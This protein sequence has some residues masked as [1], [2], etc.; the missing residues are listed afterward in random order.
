[1]ATP[2]SIEEDD[3]PGLASVAAPVLDRDLV[4]RAA[5]SV[6]GPVARVTGEHA[7]RMASW[8][9]A[10]ASKLTSLEAQWWS[11]SGYR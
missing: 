11:G 3:E 2:Y 9:I 6:A 8:V 10:A 4:A 7:T 5:I 1:M